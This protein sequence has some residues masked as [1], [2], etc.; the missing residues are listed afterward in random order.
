MTASHLGLRP[1]PLPERPAWRRAL[2]ARIDRWMAQP[3]LYRRALALPF[4]RW[5]TQRRAERLFGVMAGFV[6][7]QVL[8][9]CVRLRVFEHVFERPRTLDELASLTGMPA[10]ALERLRRPRPGRRWC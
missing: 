9:A 3:S 6:H 4:A 8:L 1:L 7:S 10:E 2:D 5:M